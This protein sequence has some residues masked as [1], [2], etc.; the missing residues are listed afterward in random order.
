MTNHD[1]DTVTVIDGTD[2]NTTTVKVGT[3]P[4][5]IAVNP[6]TGLAYVGN[7]GDNMV[8][9]ID[10]AVPSAVQKSVSFTVGRNS[11]NDNG[12]ALSLAAATLL[13]DGGLLAPVRSLD[14]ALGAL[15]T[16]D[17]HRRAVSIIK[18][19]TGLELVIGSATLNN[20][21]G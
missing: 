10:G 2:N 1:S 15:T 6:A 16:W 14:D 5:A 9:V 21:A 20:N 19:N 11:C 7:C 17:A 4:D 8:T 12:Q 13:V 3:G 18:G